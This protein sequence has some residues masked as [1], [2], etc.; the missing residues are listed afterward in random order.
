MNWLHRIVRKAQVWQ[1]PPE[2]Q[3]EDEFAADVR[4]LYRLSYLYFGVEDRIRNTADQYMRRFDNILGNLRA[5]IAEVGGKIREVLVEVME[6][7]L[8]SHALLN[9]HQWAEARVGDSDEFGTDAINNALAEFR[10]YKEWGE[11]LDP[12]RALYRDIN[13]LPYF[14]EYGLEV[15]QN[16]DPEVLTEVYGMPEGADQLEWVDQF[17]KENAEGDWTEYMG[18]G[19]FEDC[20]RLPS[21]VQREIAV[22]LNEKLVFPRW[23]GKWKNEGIDQTR[24]TA[25]KNYQILLNADPNNIGEFIAAV[26]IGLNT[27]HQNGSMLEYIGCA[28]DR[29][30]KREL[31]A[32]TGGLYTEQW[33]QQLE[34]LFIPEQI[35]QQVQPQTQQVTAQNWLCRLA[36]RFEV[37]PAD[38]FSYHEQDDDFLYHVTAETKLPEIQQYGLHPNK[39]AT[40]N[41]S[42]YEGYSRGKVFF[43]ERSGVGYWRDRIEDQLEHSMD[44]PPALVVVRF[45]KSGVWRQEQDTEGTRDSRRPSYF[46]KYPIGVSPQ[47]AMDAGYVWED[48]E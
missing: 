23:Y 9:P 48:E 35:P 2:V 3:G 19:G 39:P 36:A 32:C 46:S 30:V 28:D 42:F 6:K 29:E 1:R 43:C 40:W 38:S 13:N 5:G 22:M 47:E 7:W 18:I 17:L 15:L 8:K 31:D 41:R 25:E 44:D 24:A 20:D 34:S 21:N 45:P 10:Y 37:L 33:D 26:N 11:E 27:M 16:E 14:R 12:W 4:E